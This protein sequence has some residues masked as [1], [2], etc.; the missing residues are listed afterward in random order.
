M[1]RKAIESIRIDPAHAAVCRKRVQALVAYY[2][3][4][5]GTV[6]LNDLVISAY[7]QGIMDG[8][9]LTPT[10]NLPEAIPAECAQGLPMLPHSDQF[11]PHF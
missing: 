10:A 9:Q 5:A 4:R 8:H 1:N 3:N 7:I 6:T 2:W 11:P